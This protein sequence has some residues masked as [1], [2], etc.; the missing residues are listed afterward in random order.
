[1]KDFIDKNNDKMINLSIKEEVK[2]LIEYS[3]ENQIK[4]EF[5]KID[6]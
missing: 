5:I 3:K 1:M 6:T 2:E 4:I